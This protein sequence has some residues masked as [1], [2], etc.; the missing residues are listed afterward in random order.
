MIAAGSDSAKKVFTMMTSSYDNPATQQ[1]R[2]VLG[3]LDV[4]GT[5]ETSSLRRSSRSPVR[6]AVLAE[7][8]DDVPIVSPAHTSIDARSQSIVSDNEDDAA[9]S[10]SETETEQ[11]GLLAALA[12]HGSGRR[13]GKKRT[14]RL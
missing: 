3:R 14:V 5:S 6:A 7:A 2:P 1:P 12:K 13:G 10:S 11:G 4:P 9:D 8:G